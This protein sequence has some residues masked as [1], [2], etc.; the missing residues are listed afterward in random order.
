MNVMLPA[1]CPSMT[2]CCTCGAGAYSA[3]PGWFAS[4]VQVPMPMKVTFDPEIEHTLVVV[5][6]TVRVTGKPELAVAETAYELP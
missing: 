1:A 6:S 2:D 5:E 4:I 3:L